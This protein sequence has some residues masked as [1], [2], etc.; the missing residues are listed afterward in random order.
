MNTCQLSSKNLKKES[1]KIQQILHNN[2]FDTSTAKNLR[3]KK[4]QEKTIR[5][6]NGQNSLTLEKRR[7]PLRNS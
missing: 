2:R 4:K 3:G 5:K 7:G 6:Y 1:N